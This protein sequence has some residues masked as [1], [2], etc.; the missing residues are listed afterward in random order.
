[1]V[2]RDELLHGLEDLYRTYRDSISF[3]QF[4]KMLIARLEERY[5]PTPDES[6]SKRRQ[7]S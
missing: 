1:M 6:F 7:H 4:V 3:E 5:G 2:Y